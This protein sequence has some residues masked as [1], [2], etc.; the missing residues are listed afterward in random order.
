MST[1]IERID[2]ARSGA[3]SATAVEYATFPNAMPSSQE[4]APRLGRAYATGTAGQHEVYEKMK[5]LGYQM[6]EAEAVRT[7]N[8]TA[9]AIKDRMPKDGR[10]YDLGFVR[11]FP[12]LAGTFDSADA[13]FDPERNRLYVAAAPSDDIR[14]ALSDGT[15]TRTGEMSANDA[16]INNVTW[17]DNATANHNTIKSG[18]PFNII[19]VGLTIGVGDE[20]A[21]L[22]LPDGTSVPVTL[23]A[24]TG[25]H[26]IAQRLIGR[27]SQP[28]ASCEGAKLYVMT[29]GFD[30]DAQ[31]QLAPS[32]K[33]TIIGEDV[34]PGPSLTVTG[35]HNEES[36][37]PAIYVGRSILFDGTGLDAWGDGDR[38]E[39]KRL[40]DGETDWESITGTDD[41]TVTPS[42]GML[43]VSTDW[44]SAISFGV[45]DGIQIRFRVTIGGTS[46]EVT[47]TVH[48]E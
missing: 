7:W 41:V 19:G 20:S 46:A 22:K 35:V 30:L 3:G 42:D 31:L 21:E 37:P 38:I 1:P 28:V 27:L 15:P 34:P 4:A 24:P 16:G 14:N 32:G 26:G 44:W 47:G 40:G 29:H 48:E 25:D 13:D 43:W 5:E 17:G 6:G 2:A 9:F 8:A 23:S 18:E 45:E 33:L 12:A 36:Q 10:A 39:V 11:F